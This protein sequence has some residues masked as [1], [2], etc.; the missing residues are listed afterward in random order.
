MHTFWRILLALRYAK[1]NYTTIWYT[2]PH[3]TGGDDMVQR[4]GACL[5]CI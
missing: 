5:G 4:L 1:Q 3:N 2:I